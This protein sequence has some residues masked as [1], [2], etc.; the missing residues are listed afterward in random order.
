[1]IQAWKLHEN[2]KAATQQG[3]EMKRSVGEATRAANA[4]EKFAA[5]G[6]IASQAATEGVAIQKDTMTRPFTRLRVC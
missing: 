2:V 6:A 3:S 1:M 5:S 4:M